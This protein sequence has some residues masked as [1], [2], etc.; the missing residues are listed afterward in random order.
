M[1]I[2]TIKPEFYQSPDLGRVSREFR[3][4]AAALISWADDEG[5]FRSH[6]ALVAGSLFPF[7]ADGKEFVEAGLPK[8]AEVGFIQLFEGG[9][10]FLPTFSQ[11]QRINRPTASRLKPK[12]LIPLDSV[13][14]HGVLSEPSP[15]E[16]KGRDLG[17]EKDLGRDHER[18]AAVAEPLTKKPKVV[19]QPTL[20]GVPPPEPKVKAK[21]RQQ[22]LYED[23]LQRRE[24]RLLDLG[25]DVVPD[26]DEKDRPPSPAFINATIGRW[27]EHFADTTLTRTIEGFDAAETCVVLMFDAY[28]E[29]S[30]P[31]KY[32]SPY[33]FTVLAGERTHGKYLKA[34]A[35][36][37]ERP[38]EA[39]Q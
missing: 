37:P 3:H 32:S 8:L 23:Y 30:W 6:P 34:I 20:P 26:L 36:R 38:S 17:R 25:V 13:S 10:G 12:A 5:Y 16:G 33:P 18:A 9:V 39:L 29:E 2:R 15:T 28:L 21:S 19:K 14:T 7:D 11:H 35:P 4:L 22:V 27:L 31:T 24:D 1:R